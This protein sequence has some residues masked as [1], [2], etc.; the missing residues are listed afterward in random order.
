MKRY[1]L[2]G[3]GLFLVFAVMFAPAGLL[4]R[5]VSATGIAQL[6][7]ASGTLWEGNGELLIQHRAVGRVTW[8]FRPLSVLRLQ[9]TYEW[10]LNDPD[11]RLTG[12]AS[13]SFSHLAVTLEGGIDAPAVNPWIAPYDI[14]VQGQFDLAPTTATAILTEQG[15]ALEQVSGEWHWSGGATRYTLSGRVNSTLLPPMTA[16]LEPAGGPI[17]AASVYADGNDIPLMI[18][19]PGAPG[20]FKVGITKHFTQLLGTPWPEATLITKLS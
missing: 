11:T 10:S 18:A 6:T 15:L 12:L 1:L 14:E 4:V 8:K 16:F 20:F 17:P 5:A 3:I 7:S 2:A 13:A 9:P 19:G